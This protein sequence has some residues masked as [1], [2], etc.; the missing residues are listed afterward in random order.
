M[1]EAEKSLD[2]LYIELEQAKSLEVRELISSMIKNKLQLKTIANSR[3]DYRFK[4]LDPAIAPELKFRP[5]RSIV[6]IV[7]TV[8][9]FFISLLI[10]L[11]YHYVVK[12][13]KQ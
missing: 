5:V 2:Y 8:I 13:K 7:I 11:I 6:C 1:Y 3:K 12:P 4:V 9:G 10:T